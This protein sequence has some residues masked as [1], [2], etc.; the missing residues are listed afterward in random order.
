V[1]VAGIRAILRQR[2]NE[3]ADGDWS[4]M[5]PVAE[6]R[7]LAQGIVDDL[8]ALGVWRDDYPAHPLL[9]VMKRFLR[10]SFKD[11]GFGYDGLT[12]QERG[13][14]TREEFDLLVKCLEEDAS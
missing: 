4:R 9:Q 6:A 7:C 10:Y 2:E 3:I 11:I 12:P 1:T 8:A 13:L 14:C 5:E